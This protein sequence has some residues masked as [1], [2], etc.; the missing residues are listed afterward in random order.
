MKL[1]MSA[2]LELFEANAL[3]NIRSVAFVVL[4]SL[5]WDSFEL[6]SKPIL[7]RWAPIQAKRFSYASWTQPSHCCL[8]SGLLPHRSPTGQLAAATYLSDFSL[9]AH[10]L[11]GHEDAKRHLY[12]EFCLPLMAQRCGWCTIGRVA[13]PVLNESTVFVR[14][15]DDYSLSPAG[16]NFGTQIESISLSLNPDRNFVFIN[17]GETHY[18]YLLPKARMPQISGV[19]G[20]LG[21]LGKVSIGETARSVEE[22]PFDMDDMAAMHKSQIKAV[23]MVDSR[24]DRLLEMLPKPIFLLIVSDHGELFGEDGFFGHGPFFHKILFEVPIATGIVK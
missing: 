15:F 22:I 2:K 20:A 1:Y 8:L 6:A 23:E 18:P 24:I 10:V 14:G 5:R 3:A 9:W 13:M 19:H 12:P 16:S 21:Q 4:D 11:G 7:D 17:A